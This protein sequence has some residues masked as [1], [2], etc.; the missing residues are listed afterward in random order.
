MKKL[1]I[2]S[3]KALK[4]GDVLAIETEPNADGT[5]GRWRVNGKVKTWK[6]RHLEFKVP[7]KRGLYEY[8]YITGDNFHLLHVNGTCPNCGV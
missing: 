6:T 8:G 3:A 1:T 4:Y 5:C 7:V 2:E